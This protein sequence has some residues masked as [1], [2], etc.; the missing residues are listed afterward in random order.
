MKDFWQ[1]VA[2]TP[3]EPLTGDPDKDIPRLT[4]LIR[5]R[6]GKCDNEIVD[7]I[8]KNVLPYHLFCQFTG[9]RDE[10]DLNTPEYAAMAIGEDIRDAIQG[11][12]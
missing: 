7:A 3:T 12:H 10:G 5:K 4:S 6:L 8:V 11:M 2:E 9:I 1:E